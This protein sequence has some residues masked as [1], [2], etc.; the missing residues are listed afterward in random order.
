MIISLV[1]LALTALWANKLRS[2]LTFLGVV[3]GFTSV[4]TIISALEGMMGSIEKDLSRLG[5]ATFI[6]S[7]AGGVIT[8]HEQWI[9]MQKRKGFS[10]ETDKLIME[11]CDLCKK[12]AKRSSSM[13][14]LIKYGNSSMR[15]VYVGGGTYN[16]V[17]IVDIEVAQGR[18]HSLEDDL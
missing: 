18:F 10:S 1:K 13:N 4:M 7:R 6:V 3:V 14:A 15:D 2:G 5:P 8:S 9:E 16:L 12:L 11:G 17:E